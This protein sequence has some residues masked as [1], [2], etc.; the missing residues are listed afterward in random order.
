[1]AAVGTSHI[2][3]QTPGRAMQP[4]SE[5]IF[6]GGVGTN[7]VIL[8]SHSSS[9]CKILVG[10]TVT[11]TSV[12]TYTLAVKN[13]DGAASLSTPVSIT[14]TP[15]QGPNHTVGKTHLN[16]LPPSTSGPIICQSC[17]ILNGLPPAPPGPPPIPHMRA[18]VLAP[19]I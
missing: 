9:D 5:Y 1:M 3:V 16:G 11:T 18:K 19:P 2:S 12:A 14:I 8:D 6:S 17:R 15:P 10:E 4:I 13:S 7:K